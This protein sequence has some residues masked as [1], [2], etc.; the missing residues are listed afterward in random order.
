MAHKKICKSLSAGTWI[1]IPFFVISL[2][3]HHNR[4]APTDELGSI[5]EKLGNASNFQPGRD[6]SIYVG[7]G[8]SRPA[9][10][11]IHG[12]NAF[13]VKL[14]V[15]LDNRQSDTTTSILVYDRR[16]SFEVHIPVKMTDPTKYRLVE[17][18]CR[19]KG[20][21]GL[22]MYRW[23]R[24]VGDWKLAICLDREPVDEIKW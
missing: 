12:D 13:L 9:P 23:A 16:R 6:G 2:G 24:R 3:F 1:D 17:Y 15:P 14:Q 19:S 8:D 5:F 10:P 18:T 20:V 7:E 4:H 22:K 11:N 21:G